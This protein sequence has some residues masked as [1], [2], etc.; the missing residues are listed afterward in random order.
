MLESQASTLQEQGEPSWAAVEYYRAKQRGD[1]LGQE[2]GK[3]LWDWGIPTVVT[4]IEAVQSVSVPVIASGGVRTGSDVAKSLTLGA[5]LA[6]FALPVLGPSLKDSEEVKMKLDLVIRQLRTIMFLVGASSIE[7]L[8][9]V[10]VI[11]SGKT[12]EW[13]RARGFNLV[14]YAGRGG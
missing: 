14:S 11:V 2:I 6:G 13:L 4:L 10:P 3:D 1:I 5:S 12:A 9:A 7:G 8:K